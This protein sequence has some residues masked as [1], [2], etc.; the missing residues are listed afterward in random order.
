MKTLTI[1]VVAQAALLLLGC[2]ELIR[3]ASAKTLTPTEMR[4]TVGT[5]ANGGKCTESC[6]RYNNYNSECLGKN[7]GTSCNKCT[8]NGKSINTLDQASGACPAGLKGFQQDP[9]GI[10]TDCGSHQLGLCKSNV[11]SSQLVNSGTCNDPINIISQ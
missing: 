8:E 10:S 6:A 7:N 2:F 3:S 5:H 1:A 9:A 4:R 11:C